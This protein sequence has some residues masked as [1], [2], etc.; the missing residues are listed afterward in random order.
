VDG[1][2]IHRLFRGQ[3]VRDQ[4]LTRLLGYRLSRNGH[5]QIEVRIAN[6]HGERTLWGEGQGAISALVDAWTRA[7]GQSIQVLDYQEHAIGEGTDAE[8]AAY[9]LMSIDG[10]RVAGA[11]IDRD[12]VGAS[13][14]A[15]LS[16][17]NRVA[18]EAMPEPTTRPAKAA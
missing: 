10:T 9:A 13:L 18:S 11:A 1:A 2:N 3:F 7:S 8:A 12:V 4:G 6:A 5:D 17:L 16:A 15:V 14:K